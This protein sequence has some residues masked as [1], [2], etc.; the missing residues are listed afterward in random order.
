[1]TKRTTTLMNEADALTRTACA[2]VDL[3]DDMKDAGQD[4]SE[5]Y[6]AMVRELEDVRSRRDALVAIIKTRDPGTP[7]NYVRAYIYG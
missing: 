2:L 1:M 5:L 3:R 4:G 6:A 7:R